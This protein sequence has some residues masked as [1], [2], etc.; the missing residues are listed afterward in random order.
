[1]IASNKIVQLGVQKVNAT[2]YRDDSNRRFGQDWVLGLTT[3]EE[4]EP[5][6]AEMPGMFSFWGNVVGLAV[7]KKWILKS[8]GFGQ[9]GIER[10]RR[11]FQF[12]AQVMGLVQK[13][14]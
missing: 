4:T 10:K 5:S 14:K 1:M 11:G 12:K 9:E 8:G 13:K 7:Q 6:Q 3:K 2:E